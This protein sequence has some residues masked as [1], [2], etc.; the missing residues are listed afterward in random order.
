M[1]LT[2][3]MY[4]YF[5]LISI[6]VMCFAYP[7]D[8]FEPLDCV[9]CPGGEYLDQNTLNCTTCPVRSSSFAYSNASSTLDCLC[10]AGFENTTGNALCTACPTGLYKSTLANITCSTCFE[11]SF[12]L[13]S[14]SD[15]V[16]DCVCNAGYT[17]DPVAIDPAYEI[18]LPC[19]PGTFKNI[20]SD[21]ACEV[22]PNN[23]YC[24]LA[25]I[26]P[27]LCPPDSSSVAGS[28]VVEDCL[29][30]TGHHI[31]SATGVEY[32]CLECQPGTYNDQ[33]NQTECFLCPENT[34]N[35]NTTSSSI[36][37]CLSCDPNS[38]SALASTNI[39]NCRCNVGYSG[40]PGQVCKACEPGTYNEN[41]D[42]HICELCPPGTYNVDFAA[43]SDEYCLPCGPNTS[44]VAGSRSKQACVCEKG[45]FATLRYADTGNY[46]ECTACDAGSYNP[47]INSSSCDL[48]SPGKFSTGVAATSDTTCSTC[49]NGTFTIEAGMT[50]C[51]ECP[52]N[53]WQDL[54]NPENKAS[55]CSLCPINST[56]TEIGVYDVHTCLCV[57]G[58]QKEIVE[59][60][61][62]CALCDAGSFCPHSG[63]IELCTQNTFSV[64]GVTVQCTDCA[65]F[66]QGVHGN[67]GLDAP[68]KCQCIA[69]AEGTFHDD[70]TL[71][72]PG[73]FQP[74]DYT[75]DGNDASVDD[76]IVT[77]CEPCASDTFQQLFGQTSCV[78]CPANSSTVE[79]V[80]HT[81]G[82]DCKC[83]PGFTGNDGEVCTVCSA[84]K[85]CPGG[86]SN[87]N[88][89][90]FS[91]SPPGSISQHDCSC[92]AGFYSLSTNSSCLKCPAGTY[93]PG[94]LA[95]LSCAG[96]SS[97][98]AGSGSAEDCL[99][100]SG[101][102]RGCVLNTQ[103]IYVNSK[104]ESC[105]L[106]YDAP[107][108][109]CGPNDICVND[110]LLHCPD[111]STSPVGS[112]LP[113]HCVCDDGYYAE[114]NFYN[115]HE[116]KTDH[117]EHTE[118]NEHEIS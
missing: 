46:Y 92:N 43:D 37:A 20:L 33:V 89:R 59:D 81:L 42:I 51:T 76:S 118:H 109:Q 72:V 78:G 107:C 18:C 47:S 102:W 63:T 105:V 41:P 55:K 5:C 25:T 9:A 83:D 28:S 19:A 90:I 116:E 1:R 77:T 26:T 96:N 113:Q 108:F 82:T 14:G 117:T 73:K 69:G 62:E 112:T 29:C 3:P 53:T 84:G 114:Y 15:H 56:H 16:E 95:S 100:Q 34:Y 99:C 8:T 49:A 74:Y 67:E 22:C 17:K 71:C 66:S 35:P 91:S 21:I 110:T 75:Y 54:K 44:S 79:S 111:H 39:Q 93:C 115:T 12:T 101:Y 45:F 36:D 23:N 7:E 10:M 40:I 50:I 85:F 30:H 97:S 87:P 38:A 98:K 27:I 70:C 57:P 6:C 11:N 31:N 65:E 103:G 104:N 106:N 32:G 58:L 60:V 88:C 68:G 2:Q 24:P 94:G 52:I 64:T 86:S 80:G 61:F 13:E 48:C 4:V